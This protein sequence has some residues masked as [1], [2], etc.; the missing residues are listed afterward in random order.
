MFLRNC[1]YV[2]GW[3]KD[4]GRELKAEMFLGEQIVFYR[5]ED[6]TPVALEDACPHRKLPLSDGTLKGDR[7]ECGYHGLTFDRRGACVAAPTQKHNVPRRASVKSYPVV[8][9]YRFLWIW[10]GD[11]ALAVPDRIFPIDNFED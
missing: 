3:S 5:Q 1:W 2:A 8:D 4:V 10:M 6:G 9:R 7:V 11:P